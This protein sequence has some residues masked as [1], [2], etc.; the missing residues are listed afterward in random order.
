MFFA[1]CRDD[2]TAPPPDPPQAATITVSPATADLAAL[3][4]T[5]QLSAEVLDQN[6]QVMTGA[7]VTWASGTV[8]VATVSAS[9][10]V[11]AVANG[12]ATITATSGS[13]SGSAAVTVMQSADSV[14]VLPAEASFA[15]VGDTVRLVAEAH[16][17]N[18]NTVAG[19]EFSWESGDEAVATVGAS[20]LVT[21]VANGSAT[22]TATSGSASGSAAVTVMQSADSVAVLP[23]EAS[24]AAVGDTVRLVAEAHDANGNTV[25]GAEFSWESGDEAVATVGA[26]GL[27]TAVANGSATITATSGSASGKATVTVAQEVVTLAVLP[28][29]LTSAQ[30]GKQGADTIEVTVLDGRGSPVVG[31]RYRWSTDLHSGWVYP[32]EGITDGRGRFRTTWVAGWPGEGT[33]SVTVENEFSRATE[34]LA[35]L[36]TTP[37]NPPNGAATIHID[38]QNN[39]SAGYSIDM[40]PLTEPT[41]TYYG[42]ISWDGGY[43]GLQRGG[44]RYDRQLQFSVWDAPGH[45]NAELID[46]ASDVLCR[47]FIQNQET[48]I[49]CE[50]DYPWKVGSTYRFEVTEEEVRGG[51]AMTL[52]VS[53]L[54]TE[55][56]RFVGTI[57]FARRARMTSFAMFMEDFVRRAEHCLAREARSAAFRR[58]RTLL[59]GAWVALAE[60]M[61]GT[62]SLWPEDPLNPGTPDCAN[63]AARE[64]AAGLQLVIGGE[65]AR[66]PN[67]SRDYTVP[68][69]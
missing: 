63:V 48:G 61:R 42:A 25:A 39:P 41:G 18:G 54:A 36:S 23:A 10:L 15:A 51:S 60:M 16:D 45:G 32:P 22:I 4:A 17:A 31:A 59:D 49:A 8:A 69:H 26:S 30:A 27:V 62:L 55:S 52:H 14:A 11:T 68:R 5:V 47:T 3:G 13:A 38:N 37:G 24:F 28:A 66:D 7:T 40:T 6:G 33:L 67:A 46:K 19:A 65:T 53:D 1:A 44:S 57:R 43:A 2:A 58:P 64:H 56:R 35:T 34:D 20:G 29:R 50:L 12:S 21:A 9:G